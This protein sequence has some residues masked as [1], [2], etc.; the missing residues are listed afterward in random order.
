MRTKILAVVVG[1]TLAQAVSAAPISLSATLVGDPRV[2]NPDN[3]IVNVSVVGDT[4]SNAVNWTVDINSPAHPNAK[5]DVFAF[6]MVGGFGGY[7]FSNFGPTGWSITNGTNVPG[8]GGADFLFESNDPP[9]STNNVTNAVNLTFTMTKLAGNFTDA[10][11][12]NAPVDYLAGNPAW[13]GQMGA[14]LQS[15]TIGNCTSCTSDSGFAIGSWD[16][17]AP[18]N[19]VP[20]PASLALFG[21]GLTVLALRKR[22]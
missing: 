6:N 19:E 13:A 11:F 14:H 9:G 2:A 16:R 20:E 10:D 18:P 1:M 7:A 4:T 12:L 3:L 17:P 8:S 22:K 5:L 15:L 21:L